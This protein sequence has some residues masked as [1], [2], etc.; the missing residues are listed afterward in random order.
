[1]QRY[2]HRVVH[3]RVVYY[4]KNL[5]KNQTAKEYWLDKWW[6]IHLSFKNDVNHDILFSEKEL[7]T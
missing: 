7:Y 5:G 2:V 6:H 4:I 1:M 3:H